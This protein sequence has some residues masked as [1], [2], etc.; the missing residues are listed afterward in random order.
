MTSYMTY[1]ELH[2]KDS[3]SFIGSRTYF[4]LSYYKKSRGILN[5]E[6]LP[7]QSQCCYI[8]SNIPDHIQKRAGWGTAMI[9]SP[10]LH[11]LINRHT[12]S[13]LFK[14]Y[15]SSLFSSD[16]TFTHLPSSSTIMHLK[17][18]SGVT[19]SSLSPEH[20]N[21]RNSYQ[22]KFFLQLFHNWW[23]LHQYPSSKRGTQ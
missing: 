17:H 3:F 23:R 9:H 8:Y 1:L 19:P 5:K 16:T 14:F 13:Q 22:P 2:S 15:Y 7:H 21:H 20:K 4:S 6:L 18:T 12:I 11:F 10:T